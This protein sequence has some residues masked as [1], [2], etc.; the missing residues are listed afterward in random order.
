[1][2]YHCFLL[3]P[4]LTSNRIKSNQIKSQRIKSQRTEKMEESLLSNTTREGGNTSTT[5]VIVQQESHRAAWAIVLLVAL[6]VGLA[7]IQLCFSF[8]SFDGNQ[9]HQH[10]DYRP[11]NIKQALRNRPFDV[12]ESEEN[13]TAEK[14]VAL[15]RNLFSA[16]QTESVQHKNEE[17]KIMAW[18]EDNP[19]IEQP[20]LNYKPTYHYTSPQ[21]PGS[22][23]MTDSTASKLHDSEAF[24][25]RIAWLTSFPN[26]GTSFTMGLVA[27]AT[28]TTFATNYG[29]EANFGSKEV[30]SLSIYERHPEGP[31]MPDPVTSFHHRKL[32]YGKYVMTKTHCGGYCF[33]CRP[34]T[35]AYGYREEADERMPSL[36]PP[37]LSFL[38]DCASGHAV[39]DRGNIVDVSYPPERVSRV[40]HLIRNPIHNLIARFHLE[41]KHHSDANTASDRQWL[42]EHPDNQV[43]MSKFCDEENDRRWDEETK[44]F[45]SDFFRSNDG[46]SATETSFSRRNGDSNSPTESRF[47]EDFEAW[48]ELTQRVPCR[49][50]LFRYVQWHN[51]LHQSLDFMPYKLP[52]LTL[53]YEGFESPTYEAT[54]NSI[55]D[56]LE[57]E[58]VPGDDRGNIKW[59]EFRSRSDYD[60]FFS[61]TQTQAIMEFLQTLS[62]FRVWGEIEHY[63][64]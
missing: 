10:F 8:F 30:A 36:P 47:P 17:P 22:F 32:P 33:N 62:S 43:G 37:G 9:E 20:N 57:L 14:K 34:E 16:I 46:E 48:K 63:F 54:A 25:P 50:D 38:G 6:N 49:G 26:S 51:L 52:V 64:R 56:F 39:D 27:R 58:A 3:P 18:G 29:I 1:M 31:F 35:Y 19:N 28:N 23:F 4:S 40:I 44:F 13:F 5:K 42:E 55:L 41:R 60:D 15:R 12:K 59:S 2:N 11:G 61:S 7:G 21:Q 24:N 45:D 53:F